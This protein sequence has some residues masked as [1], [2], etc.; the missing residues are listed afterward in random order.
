MIDLKQLRHVLTLAEHRNYSRAAAALSLSQPALTRSIQS[1]ERTMGVRLFDRNRS[2]VWLT[3]MGARLVELGE[4]LLRQAARVEN[5]L[6][7]IAGLASGDL[8]IGAGPYVTDISIATAVSRFLDRH[9]EIRIDVTTSN[10]PDLASRVLDADFDLAVVELSDIDQSEQLRTDPLPRHPV[11][12]FCSVNHPLAGRSRVTLDDL[13]SSPLVSTPLPSRV[14]GLIGLEQE[15]ARAART[16]RTSPSILVDSVHVARQIVMGS[17]TIGLAALCQI[18]AEVDSGR[19]AVLPLVLPAL[20]THYGVVRMADRTPSP[21]ASGF[22][23]V[24][25]QVEEEISDEERA[26]GLFSLR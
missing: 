26:G 17:S 4:P 19:L 7:L 2:G 1:L 13:K 23:E 12:F 3:P 11:Y 5:D 24:L 15:A 22:V 14:A 9:P 10:W 6:N 21:A 25:K 16:T 20:E 8:K 18:K